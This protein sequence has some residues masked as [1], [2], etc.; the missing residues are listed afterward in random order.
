MPQKKKSQAGN[1]FTNGHQ[2]EPSGA[3]NNSGE[4]IEDKKAKDKRIKEIYRQNGVF[5]LEDIGT[6]VDSLL[7]EYIVTEKD[8]KDIQEAKF[9]YQD[10]LIQGHM[11][12]LV[13]M[14]NGGK[15]AILIHMAAELAAAGF[16]VYYFNLDA[17]A[18]GIAYAYKHAYENDYV[19]VNPDIKIGRSVEDCI[20]VL[21]TIANL[22]TDISNAVIIL[23]TLKKCTSVNQKGQAKEFYKILRKLTARGVSV[24]AAGHA[25]KYRDHEDNL[26]YEGTGDLRADFDDLIY[27]EYLRDEING[28]QTMTT[29]PDKQRGVFKRRTFTLD[30]ESRKISYEKN[31]KD[32]K[33]MVV[34]GELAA[35]KDDDVLRECVHDALR[36]GDKNLNQIK[37][38]AQKRD[39]AMRRMETHLKLFSDPSTPGRYLSRETGQNNAQIYALL[40]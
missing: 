34:K 18:E 5:D 36:D 3:V 21:E 12:V 29:Y 16:K 38:F 11:M 2:A 33:N 17:P 15:T 35:S 37:N 39:I 24:A 1:S 30:L 19:L 13:A 8:V 25:L 7:H 23:D 14:P 40:P 32:V 27:L 4:S 6:T 26:V 9:I 28:E 31:V 20:N 10:V 22:K